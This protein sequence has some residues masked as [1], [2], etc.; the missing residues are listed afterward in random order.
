MSLLSIE[1]AAFFNGMDTY[2]N[3]TMSLHVLICIQNESL[4]DYAQEIVNFLSGGLLLNICSHICTFSQCNIESFENSAYDV[5]I[6]LIHSQ[7]YNWDLSVIASLMELCAKE[8]AAPT[9]VAILGCCGG[10]SYSLWQY[11]DDVT[12]V[13]YQ[14]KSHH[15][16]LSTM[17][18]CQ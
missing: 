17:C 2:R 1:M 13:R 10:S 8:E 14:D 5:A 18:L 16:L 9:I 12:S 4:M 11:S 7:V 3:P 15:W 6:F